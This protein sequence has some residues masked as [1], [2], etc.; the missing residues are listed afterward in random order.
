[1][2]II[3]A[4]IWLAENTQSDTLTEV[5]KTNIAKIKLQLVY[6]MQGCLSLEHMPTI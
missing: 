5:L 2:N 4:C 1:M 3:G 6:K